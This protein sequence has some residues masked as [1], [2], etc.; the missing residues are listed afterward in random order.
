MTLTLEN[1]LTNTASRN[2]DAIHDKTAALGE[3]MTTGMNVLAEVVDSFLGRSLNDKEVLLG[4]VAKNTSY[5][6][7]MINVAD[8][9][10]NMIGTLTQECISIIESAAGKSSDKV[11]ILT[12]DLN[13]K[14][15]Q[16]NLLIN[17]AKFDG[18][19]LLNGSVR[20]LD[21]QVGQSISETI[22]VDI[23]NIG[24]GRLFRS[25]LANRINDVMAVEWDWAAKPNGPTNNRHYAK[26]SEIAAD[27]KENMNLIQTSE[28][29]G[30]W[31]KSKGSNLAPNS[32]TSWLSA[33]EIFHNAING[34][35]AHHAE[36]LNQLLPRELEALKNPVGAPA[37]PNKNFTNASAAE[38]EVAIKKVGLNITYSPELTRVMYDDQQLELGTNNDI[39]VSR[40]IFKGALETVRRAQ[41]SIS[42][43]KRNISDVADAIRSTTN[44]VQKASDSYLKTDYVLSSQ[45]YAENIAKLTATIT[46][47]EA[48][49]KI[50]DAAQRL[51]DDLVK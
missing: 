1:S 4:A 6:S 27:H 20:N 8:E 51:V 25:S 33:A 39:I 26:R 18:K 42:N 16:I 47:L 5:A 10:L 22:E 11:A 30:P 31:V 41:A 28:K 19:L 24:E 2:A 38:L 49:N 46:T 34:A 15:E 50:P 37:V 36:L 9:Y 48:G 23:M 17:T 43:Q 29:K 14:K 44:E 35:G 21:I 32:V 7:N 3:S 13:D 40:D 12:K 45:Q